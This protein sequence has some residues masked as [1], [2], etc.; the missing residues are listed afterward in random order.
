MSVFLKR[1][2]N[3]QCNRYCFENPV[4]AVLHMMS[5]IE[6]FFIP[7]ICFGIS[8]SAGLSANDTQ[9]MMHLLPRHMI[10][11]LDATED[12]G[13]DQT[14]TFWEWTRSARNIRTE[15]SMIPRPEFV[16]LL[17]MVSD[18]ENK[19]SI[20]WFECAM[21][22][23]Y[24][25]S[26]NDYLIAS[27]LGT[28]LVC[29][30]IGD[31]IRIDLSDLSLTGTIHLESLPQTVRSLDLSFNDLDTLNL[32]ALRGKGLRRLSVE[33]N[34]R[35]RL[36]MNV[37]DSDLGRN[38][39]LRTLQL[40]FNQIFPEIVDSKLKL[41]KIQKLMDNHR[42][43]NVMIVDGV[44][45]PRGALI[46]RIAFPQ[47]IGNVVKG[48]TNK[49][50]I[51]WYTY[52]VRFQHLPRREL[53]RFGIYSADRRRN[54]YRG[55]YELDLSGLGLEGHVDLGHLPRNVIKLDLSN[56]NLSSISFMGEGKY[57]LGLLNLWNNDNLRIDLSAID[58]SSSRCCLFRAHWLG[59]SSNQLTH[60]Q[61]KY[62]KEWLRASTLDTLT[63]DDQIF[64]IH[65]QLREENIK[66][67]WYPMASG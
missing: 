67:V 44:S 14:L 61:P 52:F 26:A 40:S 62:V 31:L 27:Q 57:N 33:R 29:D 6:I 17:E 63:L 8:R 2:A 54:R 48:V 53:P 47:G 7:F 45:I 66:A 55:K 28:G 39:S 64:S 12:I 25:S 18:I 10:T 11:E 32:E 51:P 20:P 19:E 21:Q 3:L 34:D 37:F 41:Y 16:L 13:F 58:Q 65:S 42:T 30:D 36:N 50:R 4:L 9:E 15:Q 38:L 35:L 60:A 43:L 24:D 1:I 5:Q 46:V 56:N 23:L 49:E 59:L 22:C